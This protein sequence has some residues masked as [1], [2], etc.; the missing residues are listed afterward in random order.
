[1]LRY[2]NI[3][4][5]LLVTLVAALLTL[6]IIFNYEK[7]LP[8]LPTKQLISVTYSTEFLT[9]KDSFANLVINMRLAELTIFSLI[10]S[11]IKYRHL[12]NVLKTVIAGLTLFAISTVI[13]YD[14]LTGNP[15]HTILRD[16]ASLIE[17]FILT[18]TSLTLIVLVVFKSLRLG[19]RIDKD[20][21]P[22]FLAIPLLLFISFNYKAQLVIDHVIIYL[23]IYLSILNLIVLGGR[24]A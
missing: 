11:A 6:T 15:F 17:A 14:L 2:K 8:T 23:T 16:Q 9:F 19:F 5:I 3:V 13:V 12:D 22:I 18:L 4:F 21:L 7:M 10:I 20:S 24:R 1:M